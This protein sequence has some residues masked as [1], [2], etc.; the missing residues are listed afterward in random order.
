MY[1]LNDSATIVQ[2]DV[3]WLS[4]S[5]HDPSACAALLE[6]RDRRFAL[7]EEQGYREKQFSAHGYHYRSRA[8]VA[9]G[10]GRREVLCQLSGGEAATGWRDCA[11]LATNVSRVD[12]AVTARP[13]VATDGLAR[14][15]YRAASERPRGRGR[16][17]ELTLIVSQDRGDTLY[18]GSR[19][20]DV[21]GRL[22]NKEKEADEPA[23]QG[24]WRWEVQYRRSYALSAVRGLQASPEASETIIGTVGR[25]FR[26]RGVSTPYREMVAGASVVAPRPTPDDERWLTWARRCVRPRAQ[27]LAE[28]YGWRFVAE[29]LVGR[30]ESIEAWETMMRDFEAGQ[31]G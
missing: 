16:S 14:A 25:W 22:Y 9:I 17:P 5:T 29:S 18:I 13:D 2:A 10:V 27:E 12:L 8:Q 3:D 28:R 7:L 30:I 6:W 4:M 31:E 26:D 23:Y 21:L 1:S 11:R 15:G 24:C 20:S 19:K